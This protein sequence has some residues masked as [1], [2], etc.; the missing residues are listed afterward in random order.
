MQKKILN[1]FKKNDPKLYTA[2]TAVGSTR[3]RGPEVQKNLF[4][5]VCKTIVGQQL[6][7]KAACAIYTRF[8]ELFPRK[9]P[10]ASKVLALSEETLRSSGLSYAKIRALHDLSE[11]V[12]NKSLKLQKLRTAGE[13]EARDMLLKVRGIGPWSC[14]MILMFSL[15]YE[16]VFSPGDLGLQK[17]IAKVYGLKKLPDEKYI[18]AVSKKWSPYRTYAACALWDIVDAK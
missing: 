17:G 2:I 9:Q 10:T 14:E 4:V 13:E 5:S 16:D 15:G 1:H 3:A 7:G 11:R 12:E 8:A 6:S 18:L